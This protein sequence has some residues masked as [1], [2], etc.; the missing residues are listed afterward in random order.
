MFF[1][2]GRAGC[3]MRFKDSYNIKRSNSNS[4]RCRT[5]SSYGKNIE[6]FQTIYVFCLAERERGSIKQFNSDDTPNASSV[7]TVGAGGFD[8]DGH[9]DGRCKE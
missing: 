7:A 1:G 8:G 2:W 5:C 4:H 6:N 3:E 9:D